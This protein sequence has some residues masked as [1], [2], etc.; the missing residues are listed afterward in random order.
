MESLLLGTRKISA[1][2]P[3]VTL[4]LV[5]MLLSVLMTQTVSDFLP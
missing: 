3:G 1:L 4:A 2:I 5:V